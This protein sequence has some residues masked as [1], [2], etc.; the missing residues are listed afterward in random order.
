MDVAKAV[1]IVQELLQ[2]QTPLGTKI[3]L[4][5][6]EPF[7]VFDKIRCFCDTIWSDTY[8]ESYNIHVTTNGTL[9]HGPIQEW[10]SEHRSQLTP[11]LSI[12][13][14]RASHELNRP[15]SFDKID[16]DFFLGNW[17]DIQVNMTVTPAT[18]P[19]FSDNVLFLHSQGFGFINVN[20]ALMTKWSDKDLKRVFYQQLN[21]LVDFYLEN[22]DIV[23]VSLFRSDIGRTIESGIFYAPCNI[24]QKTAY[25]FDTGEY[26]PCH[27]FFP[28][29]LNRE[30][31]SKL[32][33]VNF[34]DRSSLVSQE[35]SDCPF[36][37][38]CRTCYAE[39]LMMRGSLAARDM[40]LCPYQ[41]LVFAALFKY[42]YSRILRE[43]SPT[44]D[45]FRKMMTIQK[46]QNVIRE[47]EESVC[48]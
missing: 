22:P 36:L 5:G 31:A 1:S 33:E 40:A 34:T 3:K 21:Q 44:S 23:P 19:S 37:N 29:V 11:K 8:P 9:V 32:N 10:L 38:I 47:I 17:P 20:F 12:D 46:W 27:M 13:G 7:I 2:T 14:T 45:D 42:E 26:Y 15:G 16:M 25:D 4:H 41:K 6:G 43:E 39:N 24:G 30:E 18:L 28:S 48:D 35:C